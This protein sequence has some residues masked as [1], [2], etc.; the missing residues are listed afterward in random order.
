[1]SD[2][3]TINQD[4]IQTSAQSIY[5]APSSAAANMLTSVSNYGSWNNPPALHRTQHHGPVLGGTTFGHFRSPTIPSNYSSTYP[6]WCHSQY[7]MTKQDIPSVVLETSTSYLP[8]YD[9]LPLH[10]WQNSTVPPPGSL[11]G[12]LSPMAAETSQIRFSSQPHANQPPTHQLHFLPL[13]SHPSS[14]LLLSCRWLCGDTICRFTGTVE[15]LRA[16]CKTSHFAGAPNAQIQC[17]WDACNYRKR[18]DPTVH[19]MRRDCMWR[20]TCE[21]HL[22]M[23]RGS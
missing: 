19:V 22:G 9:E 3:L 12:P 18:E 7:N 14:P 6:I 8:P 23:K 2:Q 10:Q 11:S 13:H 15:K 1:M 5:S 21:V 16:H 17:R 4:C 20:H